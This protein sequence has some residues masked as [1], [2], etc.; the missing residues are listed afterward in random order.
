MRARPRSQGRGRLLFV[1]AVAASVAASAVAIYLLRSSQAWNPPIAP[2]SNRERQQIAR[3]LRH[4]V[5]RT[6]GNNVWVK[7]LPY[8]PFPPLQ[9]E[10]PTQAAV[11]HSH[12]EHV[13]SAIEGEARSQGLR[14][15]SKVVRGADEMRLADVRLLRGRKTAGRWL[16]REIARIRY[17]AIIIDD[18]GQDL[19]AARQLIA[20]P[21][22]ITFAVLPHLVHSTATAQEVH[23]AGREVMLHIPMEPDSTARPGPGEIRVGMRGTEVDRLVEED[24]NSVPF[25]A[26][27]NNHMGSRATTDPRL[28]ADFMEV[29]AARHLFFVDSRTTPASVALAAA[30]RRGIPA[31][32]RSVFLDDVETVPYALGKLQ[33]FMRVVLDEDT[34][35]AI[36][37]PYPT[38]LTALRQFLPELERQGIRLVPASQLLGLPE[39]AQL[40]PPRR[41]SR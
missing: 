6:G 8:A 15:K 4:A 18:L 41:T 27:V 40:N 32:Y 17:A 22:S 38:T 28:M 13:L 12:F 20:L 29:L 5:E 37:H 1:A 34:A 10:T 19:S 14:T 7:D 33:E 9:V 39:V 25:A 11:A 2:I 26:G 23:Q 36:G 3:R 16:L 31:F 24:L 30:R 21:Y 35:V